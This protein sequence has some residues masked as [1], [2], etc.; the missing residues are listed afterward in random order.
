MKNALIVF[1]ILPTNSVKK[2]I[3]I[4]LE[5]LYEDVGA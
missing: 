3:E 4:S 2:C 1:H 5:N